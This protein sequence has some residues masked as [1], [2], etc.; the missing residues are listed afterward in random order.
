MALLYTHS[1]LGAGPRATPIIIQ[2]STLF[3]T[4]FVFCHWLHAHC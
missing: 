4:G 1:I 3:L 2:C